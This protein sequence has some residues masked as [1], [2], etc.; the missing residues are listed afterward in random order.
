MSAPD[1]AADDNQKNPNSYYY[2]HGHEKERAKVGDVAPKTA[3]MLVKSEGSAEPAS[4]F[5]RPID[6]YSWCNNTASVSVYVDIEGVD[7]LPEGAVQISF[8]EQSFRL[9]ITNAAG[10]P[11]LL[12]LHL[13]K[14]IVAEKSSIRLKPNQIVM[15]LVK[16]NHEE[17]WF[18]LVSGAAAHSDEE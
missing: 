2:W 1:A 8:K 9:T 7:T 18:D 17:T 10:V 16:A 15:K 11:H 6:K 3:P 14:K 12:H 4:P 5:C 13:A